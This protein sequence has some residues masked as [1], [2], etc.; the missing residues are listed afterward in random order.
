MEVLQGEEKGAPGKGEA[1]GEGTHTK[2]LEGRELMEGLGGG[3]CG[4]GTGRDRAGE[5]AESSSQNPGT[6]RM[7]PAAGTLGMCPA[8]PS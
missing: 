8:L 2:A 1:V 3:G 7:Q 6:R 5:C 4:V